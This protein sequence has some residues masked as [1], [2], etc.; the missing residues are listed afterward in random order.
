MNSIY[1]IIPALN[2]NVNKDYS[3]INAMTSITQDDFIALVRK[4]RQISLLVVGEYNAEK[5]N[6]GL[7][8][9]KEMLTN[10]YKILKEQN[11][12]KDKTF[13]MGKLLMFFNDFD[14]VKPSEDSAF[15][16]SHTDLEPHADLIYAYLQ[17]Q[18]TSALA[19]V[20]GL[21]NPDS[22]IRIEYQGKWI[23]LT[24]F[25]TSTDLYKWLIEHRTPQ[26]KYDFNY[27]KHGKTAR[28]KRYG[29]TISPVTYSKDDLKKF[30]KKAVGTNLKHDELY[31][32]D[33]PHRKYVIFFDENT[34]DN[35]YHAFEFPQNSNKEVE[36]IWER[37][38]RDLMERILIVAEME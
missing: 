19:D 27:R 2:N 38:K 1:F 14:D 33:K 6:L 34:S 13:E 16:A 24:V 8:Y 25:K 3:Q 21:K 9:A 26:R 4:M 29:P 30:L 10:I 35:L 15:N 17:N 36:K 20:N 22:G 11:Q 32:Y 31:Y 7:Y 37:G 23:T 12:D 28:E 18:K 5:K